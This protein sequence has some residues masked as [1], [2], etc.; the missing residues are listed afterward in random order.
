MGKEKAAIETANVPMAQKTIS[1]NVWSI[2]SV[3]R[4]RRALLDEAQWE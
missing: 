4:I 2:K 3:K 1:G